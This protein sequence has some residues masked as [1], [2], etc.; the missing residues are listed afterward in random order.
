MIPKQRH[1]PIIDRRCRAPLA[2]PRNT[3]AS[4]HLSRCTRTDEKAHSR[5]LDPPEPS[6]SSPRGLKCF[7]LHTARLCRPPLSKHKLAAATFPTDFWWRCERCSWRPPSR[8]WLS[9]CRV[10]GE[11]AGWLHAGGAAAAWQG[12]EESSSSCST[13]LA[14]TQAQ[15]ASVASVVPRLVGFANRRTSTLYQAQ[16]Q[17]RAVKT[18]DYQLSQKT[19]ISSPFSAP[20]ALSPPRRPW[21]AEREDRD[22]KRTRLMNECGQ[23]ETAR[24]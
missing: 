1:P 13:V 15:T 9:L 21:Q 5:L 23:L 16:Q 17:T 4:L 10:V 19:P 11:N 20:R 12:T 18:A 8:N 6:S 22:R 14:K 24:R 7:A 3:S 2:R